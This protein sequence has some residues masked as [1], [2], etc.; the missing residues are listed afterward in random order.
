MDTTTLQNL[1]K[2]NSDILCLDDGLRIGVDPSWVVANESKLSYTTIIRLIECCREYHWQ[3]DIEPHLL[4]LKI[5]ST[6]R[7]IK[8]DF[9]VPIKI[10][11]MLDIV[12]QVS[13]IHKR[14]YILHFS[15]RTCDRTITH[16][17]MELVLVFWDPL[18]NEPVTPPEYLVRTLKSLQV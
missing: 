12:Y 11:E 16:T 15:V 10:N 3:K 7:F 1:L 4:G 2:E 6:C 9:Y 17:E 13:E 5:D 8:G 18:N 14:S